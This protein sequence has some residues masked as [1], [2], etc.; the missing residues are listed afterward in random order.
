MIS[1]ELLINSDK[2]HTTE[3]GAVR[4]KR[5]LSLDTDDVVT[6]CKM[7][8]GS[9]NAIIQRKGK[10]WY[11]VVEGCTI[12]INAYSFTIITAHKEKKEIKS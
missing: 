2:L 4:I 11:I 7:K 6:W 9:P 10:N 5:N 1:N 3:L 12:T 8:I